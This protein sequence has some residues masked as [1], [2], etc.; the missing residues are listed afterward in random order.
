MILPQSQSFAPNI[1]DPQLRSFLYDVYILP[2]ENWNTKFN[3]NFRFKIYMKTA[4]LIIFP[5]TSESQKERKK[6]CLFLYIWRFVCLFCVFSFFVLSV[7]ILFQNFS[8]VFVYFMRLENYYFVDLTKI[9]YT[10]D[11]N[12]TYIRFETHTLPK[13]YFAYI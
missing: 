2:F 7:S 8:D 3:L 13:Q 1:L 5:Y 9:T 4:D 11:E 10:H 12:E 6:L